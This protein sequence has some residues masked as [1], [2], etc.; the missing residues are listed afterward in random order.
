M[1]LKAIVN[2]SPLIF[3]SKA[4]LLE[5]LKVLFTTVYTTKE[6]MK[7]VEKPLELGFEAPEILTIKAVNWINV[8]ELKAEEKEDAKRLALVW[9]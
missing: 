1:D 5:I 4:R 2:A 8:V 3:I 9:A 6:I 7:E